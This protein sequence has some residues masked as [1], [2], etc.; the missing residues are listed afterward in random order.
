MPLL[1][2]FF[3]KTAARV[4]EIK[5]TGHRFETPSGTTILE[6]ALKQ[7]I[8]Y[9][10]DCTVGTC[11]SCRTRLVTGRVAA[12]TPFGYTLSREELE[13]GY[14]LACQALP[15]T[16]LLLDV[17]IGSAAVTDAFRQP[18]TLEQTAELTH[19]IRQV[20]F[21]V[22]KPIHYKAGQYANIHW[23]DGPVHRS[24]S[25][26][27]APDAGGTREPTFFIR[28]VPGGRFTDQLFGGSLSGERLEIDGPHGNFWLREGKGPIICIAGGSGLAPILSLLQDAANRRIR[29]DCILLFGARGEQ[30]LYGQNSIVKIRNAWTAGF[31]FWPILSDEQSSAYRHGF[32]TNHIAQALAQLGPH[33]QAYLC[34]PPSMIDA[35]IA[36]LTDAEIQLSDIHYDKFTDAS[37]GA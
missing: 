7:G 24:Y 23:G 14:I 21:S 29:R 32:V 1:S 10:H 20:T 5:G 18:A 8:A 35:G 31:D 2:K 12:I 16:D 17:D 26:A 6:C 4:V 15:K 27:C 25:F 11:G 37:T 33:A 28:H 9:P 13:A 34:G 30:D 36:A 22:D 3:G 19:D